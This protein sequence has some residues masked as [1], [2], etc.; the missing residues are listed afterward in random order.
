MSD[1]PAKNL[2]CG[3]TSAPTVAGGGWCENQYKSRRSLLKRAVQAAQL[4]SYGPTPDRS[5]SPCFASRPLQPTLL[6]IGATA[7]GKAQNLEGENKR[8]SLKP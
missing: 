2:V 4:C 8:R 6:F 1:N 3:P 7:S 5:P